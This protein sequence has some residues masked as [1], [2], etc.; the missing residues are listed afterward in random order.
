MLQKDEYLTEQKGNDFKV[1]LKLAQIYSKGCFGWSWYQKNEVEFLRKFCN[2]HT[3]N[4]AVATSSGTAAIEA[5]LRVLGVK[6]GDEVIIPAFTWLSAATAVAAIGAIPVITDIDPE[7]F[8]LDSK[9]VEEAITE[10]TKVIMP[11]HL[12]SAIADMDSINKVA[13][14]HNLKVL[15]D[16]AHVHGAQ[17]KQQGVGSIGDMGIFSFQQ[18]KLM[19]CGEGGAIITNNLD[20]VYPTDAAVHMGWS[21]FRG[22]KP[23]TNVPCSKSLMTEFQ[24]AILS[25]QCD[26]LIA[27][28]EKREENANYFESLFDD[29]PYIKFQKTSQGTTRRSYYYLAFLL[30]TEYLKD[31][32]NKYHIL[33]D[34]NREK[35]PALNG[36]GVPI[37]KHEFWNIPQNLYVK[38]DTPIAEDISMNKVLA[39]P[40]QFLLIKKKNLKKAA[41]IVKKVIKKYVI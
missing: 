28:N 18:S 17:Y 15:E 12:F 35:L 23:M 2:L 36:W 25:S 13:K 6:A 38:K 11:V 41:E 39:F 7:T 29:F 21:A 9:K 40:H 31:G 26:D 32:I 8:C 3:A 30:N 4:F 5:S 22:K 33:N 27:L 20:L 16:C 1:I 37:Y 19:S 24:A 34:L 14:M 10:K